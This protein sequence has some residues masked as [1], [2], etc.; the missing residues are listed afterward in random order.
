MPEQ[1]GREREVARL[2]E[3]VLS[4]P[5]TT[6][7]QLTLIDQVLRRFCAFAASLP[8][9]SLSGMC[10]TLLHFLLVS[11]YVLLL[12]KGLLYSPSLK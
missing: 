5:A 9:Q 2:C 3:R 12:Q 6:V 11:A 10:E 1:G 7:E 8:E 4:P